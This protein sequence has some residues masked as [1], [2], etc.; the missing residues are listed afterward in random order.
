MPGSKSDDESVVL[1]E[2]E[3]ERAVADDDGLREEAAALD[4][5]DLERVGLFCVGTKAVAT[6]DNNTNTKLT[7]TKDRVNVIIQWYLW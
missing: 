3:A 6:L 4:D 2:N 5:H 7:E 1:L